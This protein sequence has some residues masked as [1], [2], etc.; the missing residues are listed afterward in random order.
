[1]KVKEL[2]AWSGVCAAMTLGAAPAARADVK[3]SPL[4]SDHM[5]LQ[6]G[7]DAPVWGTADAGEEVTVSVG[8]AKAA[9]KAGDDGK[10]MVK[11][12]GLP[13]T[14]SGELTIKGKNTITI[15]DVAVGEVWIASG[16]SNMEWTARNGSI[17]EETK[18]ADRPG[19]RMFTV[20]KAI[21]AQPTTELEGSWQVCTPETVGNF[22]A[23]G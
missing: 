12:K 20:K 2:I 23:V 11:L 16:Q 13:A 3:V 4:F 7:I 21:K 22:S 14:A 1:M 17:A 10:W 8:D 15:K 5:V 9:A 6:Q 18:A 19:L